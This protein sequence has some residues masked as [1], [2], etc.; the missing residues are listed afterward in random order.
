MGKISVYG[1][2]VNLRYPTMKQ[3][4]DGQD[5]CIMEMIAKGFGM[6]DNDLASFNRPRRHPQATLLSDIRNKIDKLL[7][8][9]WQETPKGLLGEN[10]STTTFG[11]ENATKED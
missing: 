9:D 10:G 5:K 3:P 11:S 1:I 4:R 6:C 2:E 8:S 7:M